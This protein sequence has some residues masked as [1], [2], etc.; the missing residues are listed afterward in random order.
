PLIIKYISIDG[1]SVELKQNF[2]VDNILAKH[3]D[4]NTIWLLGTDSAT[5][6]FALT[7][8]NQMTVVQKTLVFHGDKYII[9][10]ETDLRN[11]LR[12]MATK[13]Y[14]LSWDGGLAY[15]EPNIVDESRYSKAYAYSGGETEALDVKIDKHAEARLK[16][17]TNW[18]AIRTKYFAASFIPQNSC[19]GYKLSARGIP[20][21]GKDF[22]KRY[23]MQI[24][25]PVKDIGQTTLFV[26][27]LDYTTVKSLD[28]DLENIMSLGK[29]LRPISKGI[30]WTFI[31]LRKI[32]PNYG[33]VLI[34][35]SFLIKIVLYPLT[36]KSMQSM[37]E[38]QKLQPKIEEIKIKFKN[39]QQ[40]ISA[41][42][43]KLY[44]E[45]GVNP[46]GGCLPLLLQ[47][48][49]LIALFT[50][51]RTT[52]ELRHAPFIWWITD[53][54]AP[55]TIFTLPFTIPIYGQYVNVLPVIM[56][57]S[58]ILQQKLSGTTSTN[59]QQKMMMY[60]MPIMFFFMFNQFPSGLNLY[61]TLFNLLT[62][63]QQKLIPAK[64]K[65]KKQRPST[66]ETLRKI[67]SKTRRK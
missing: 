26:G 43:M 8:K 27:P 19:S 38:M 52:I 33:W 25:L 39:D 6:S 23:S 64:S 55:D 37:K 3:T 4:G 16:G 35:F 20:V 65:P 46:M 42:Q 2:I 32:I 30:L 40:K 7:D 45:H 22:Y 60:M 41:A 24:S 10:I 49:I 12:D 17:Q 66:I 36:N 47:M 63:A 5:I 21:S 31:H 50:V 11:L 28:A 59:P 48:P 18:T 56:A 54:S 53:L 1:D 44:K 13:H 51:F 67:Q 61:Y 58:T 34:I 15:T 29:I 14:D 62:V 57:L 9:N